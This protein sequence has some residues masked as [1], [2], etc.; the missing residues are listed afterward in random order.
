MHHVHCAAPA[1]SSRPQNRGL[2]NSRGISTE[3]IL[4]VLRRAIYG[5]RVYQASAALF[6][7]RCGNHVEIRL[8]SEKACRSSADMSKEGV[9]SETQ[10]KHG[11]FHPR[12][13]S[14]LHG[15]GQAYKVYLRRRP[16][17]YRGM[18]VL[19]LSHLGQ[20]IYSYFVI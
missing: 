18:H 1:L 14:I 16:R 8:L 9:Q 3:T 11:P 6:Q 2:R 12:L 4:V 10:L 15:Q 19:T 17:F 5:L 7:R 20:M 13:C